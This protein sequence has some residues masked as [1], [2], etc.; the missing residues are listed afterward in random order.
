[1]KFQFI[2]L[3]LAT[4]LVVSVIADTSAAHNIHAISGNT[5]LISRRDGMTVPKRLAS[6]TLRRRITEDQ[7]K[8]SEVK[9]DEEEIDENEVEE[10]EADENEV[11]VEE[12]EAD[13]NE[14]EEEEEEADENEVE[15]EEEEADEN[16]VEKDEKDWKTARRRSIQ[17]GVVLRRKE[18]DEEEEDEE[19]EDE[20]EKDEEEKDEEE[21][22]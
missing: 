22:D 21:K 3:G 6:A 9:K 14:V 2:G 10:E 8:E 19:E 13:E 4:A 15:E 20:E 7:G 12:E 16:E 17:E 11:E 1:M 5:A 18:K